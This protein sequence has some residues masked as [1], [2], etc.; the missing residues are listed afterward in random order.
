MVRIVSVVLGVL[1]TAGTVFSEGMPIRMSLRDACVM[2]VKNS[3]EV[4]RDS[5]EMDKQKW[6]RREAI[7]KLLPQIEGFSTFNYYYAIPK[8]QLPGEIFGGSGLI[9]VEFGTTYDWSS[10]FK[11][12]QVLFNRSA[13]TA[14]AIA[15]KS[16]TMAELSVRQKT[17][18]AIY[19]TA[20]VYLLCVA[21]SSQRTLLEHSLAIME[22]LY[23]IARAQAQ[24]GMLRTADCSRITVGQLTLQ[25]QID[26]LSQLL[27]E[28]TGLLAFLTG[29]P[30]GTTVIPADSL[31]DTIFVM[32]QD[33]AVRTEQRLL[34]MQVDVARHSLRLCRETQYP[35]LAL[36]AQHYFQA[37][38]NSPGFF[39]DPAGNF[40]RTGLVGI[41]L[42]VPVFDGMSTVARV[43]EAALELEQA[44]I[45]QTTAR[46]S[47]TKESED[48]R[49]RF[50]TAK[51]EIER[52]REAIE[53]AQRNYDIDVEGYRQSVIPLS[54]LLASENSVT[55]ARLAYCNALFSLHTAKLDIMKASGVLAETVE[56]D[57]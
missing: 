12:T 37:Q 27:G 21:T 55:E 45:A 3:A 24:N 48:A 32:M 38:R 13:F 50:A 46:K 31:T 43:H 26:N 11:A 57:K 29:Q 36:F 19:Q 8:M 53:L 17:E 2:A 23:D 14:Y 51:R 25:S 56:N 42:S 7:G 52:Q 16:V 20:R 5:L 22:K 10:G 33:T 54:D 9:P 39:D 34:D 44:S 47:F 6:R 18:E 49:R 28:Q 40:F 35:S 15:G 41:S 1:I 30:Q 4:C